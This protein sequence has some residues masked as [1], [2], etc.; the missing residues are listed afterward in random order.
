MDEKLEQLQT[1]NK[2]MR[3]AIEK[4]IKDLK[5]EL[6]GE[7]LSLPLSNLFDGVIYD[8][9]KAIKKWTMYLSLIG[10]KS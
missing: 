1:E 2:Q 9:R 7:F 8:L 6:E 5:D 4:V 3:E 10:R